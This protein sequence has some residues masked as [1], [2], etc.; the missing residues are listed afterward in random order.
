MKFLQQGHLVNLSSRLE[1]CFKD[2]LLATWKSNVNT[3]MI[4]TLVLVSSFETTRP[5]KNQWVSIIN[6]LDQGK[7]IIV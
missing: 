5:V 3:S 6:F 2:F 1:L 4:R 7:T